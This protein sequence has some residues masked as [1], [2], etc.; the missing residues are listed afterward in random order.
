MIPSGMLDAVVEQA[1]GRL[2]MIRS[3]AALDLYD[4]GRALIGGL[5]EVHQGRLRQ[6]APALQPPV[7]LTPLAQITRP[8]V[9]HEY[10]GSAL[11]RSCTG[12]VVSKYVKRWTNTY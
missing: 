8:D 10:V 11:D 6:H 4:L 2:D 5:V 12:I 9:C 7:R 1:V 3:I